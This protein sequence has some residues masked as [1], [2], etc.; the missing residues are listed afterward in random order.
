MP[1]CRSSQISDAQ[2]RA[3]RLP[4]NDNR[5]P[6]RSGIRPSRDSRSTLKASWQAVLFLCVT[7]LL[8]L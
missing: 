1:M 7:A 3:S 4:A 8:I 2:L 5:L 6:V